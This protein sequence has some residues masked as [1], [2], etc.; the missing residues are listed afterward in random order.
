M[1]YAR[2]MFTKNQFEL[3]VDVTKFIEVFIFSDLNRE[4][5]LLTFRKRSRSI[6][7]DLPQAGTRTSSGTTA[8]I[9]LGG[10]D[11]FWRTSGGSVI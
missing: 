9:E 8:V 1:T 6:L 2:T 7:K 5:I 4:L 10:R 3:E 11:F